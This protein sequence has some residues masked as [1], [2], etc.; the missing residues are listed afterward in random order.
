M[1]L[2]RSGGSAIRVEQGA[3][4]GETVYCDDCSLPIT[5]DRILEAQLQELFYT[6]GTWISHQPL[7]PNAVIDS[8]SSDI[9]VRNIESDGVV[10][11]SVVWRAPKPWLL[12]IQ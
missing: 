9:V 6:F 7:E 8:R 4:T 2:M 12:F 5:F 1:G 11:C 10:G 3:R